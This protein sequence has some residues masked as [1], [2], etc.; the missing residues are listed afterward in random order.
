MTNT[1]IKKLYTKTKKAY[2]KR[3]GHKHTWVMNAKQQR[4]GTATI[5]AGYPVDFGYHLRS[6]EE[7]LADIDN[8]WAKQEADY[9]KR[10]REEIRRNENHPDREPDTFWQ[11]QTTPEHLAKARQSTVDMY[12]RARDEAIAN[13]EKYGEW[14]QQYENEVKYA[15][16]M[17]NS[18]E[19]QD[20]LKQIGGN[21]FLDIKDHAAG[22]TSS[23]YSEIYIRFSYN[24][25]A[26]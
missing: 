15:E 18:P 19:I 4:L 20:F 24:A 17:L 26:E 22:K 2:E 3:T 7:K 21:A 13:I 25:D 9:H 6:A 5:L 1:E 12:V 14:K 11:E 8:I 10:A 23:R 16:E